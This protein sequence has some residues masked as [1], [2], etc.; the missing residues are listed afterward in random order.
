MG[1]SGDSGGHAMGISGGSANQRIRNHELQRRISIQSGQ[2]TIRQQCHGTGHGA[3][4]PAGHDGCADSAAGANAINNDP[5]LQNSGITA[6]VSNGQVTLMGN[7][8]SRSL[9]QHAAAVVQ[10]VPGVVSV[11]NQITNSNSSSG[12]ANPSGSAAAANPSNS[13]SGST[14]PSNQTG[15][16]DQSSQG[17]AQPGQSGNASGQNGNASGRVAIVQDNP[18]LAPAHRRPAIRDLPALLPA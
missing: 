11:T 12:S 14:N 16:S 6:T 3:I 17:Q 15:Q 2:R 9:K 13:A 4:G 10:S 7:V 5:Q 8:A 1:D 18:V